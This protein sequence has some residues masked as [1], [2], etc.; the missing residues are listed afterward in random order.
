MKRNHIESCIQ[1]IR[2]IQFCDSRL[3]AVNVR[4]F[5]SY[6]TLHKQI[7]EAVRD[8]KLTWLDMDAGAAGAMRI[9]DYFHFFPE[10]TDREQGRLRATMTSFRRRI[11]SIKPA[12]GQ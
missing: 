3:Q 6:R 1:L 12:K 11:E 7:V 9:T 5:M 8:L 4:V 10:L 2:G